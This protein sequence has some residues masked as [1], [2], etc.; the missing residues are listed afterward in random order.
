MFWVAMVSSAPLAAMNFSSLTR[1]WWAWLGGD[2]ANCARN[3]P[4]TAQMT[5][6]L[7]GKAEAW[8]AASRSL[9]DHIP[10]GPR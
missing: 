9:L 7:L 3:A 5:G 4:L 8:W 1:A 6:R 10:P 2:S